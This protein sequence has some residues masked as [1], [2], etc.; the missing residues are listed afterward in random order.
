[1][2]YYK[3]S[4]LKNDDFIENIR[5]LYPTSFTLPEFDKF[6]ND[7]DIIKFENDDLINFQ[8]YN[9]NIYLLFV[10]INAIKV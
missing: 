6:H 2:I 7:N 4:E 10:M 1:M 9:Y 8:L 3:I 5:I